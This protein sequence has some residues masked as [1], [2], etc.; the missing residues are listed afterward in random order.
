MLYR[1]LKIIVGIGIRFYYKEVKVLNRTSLSQDGPLIIIS[2]HP[3]TLMDAM[4]IGFACK[5]PIYYMAK[6][7]LFNSK[8]KLWLLQSLNMIPINRQG[9]GATKGVSNQDSF[10]AC[11]RIL[12]QNKTLV[13]FPEGT[14]FLERQLRELK[15]GTARIA[16]EV[17]KRNN[18]KLNL[19]VV[20]LG[21]N[22]L[23]GE[24]FR[25]SV[26]I[27]VG[28]KLSVIDFLEDYKVDAGKTAKKLT[29]KFR[30]NLETVLVNSTSKEQEFLVDDLVEILSSR[31]LRANDKGVE[32]DVSF[33]KDIRNKVEGLQL[34]DPKK[35]AE[36]QLLV[37]N[38]QW[39]LRKLDIRADFLDRRFRSLMFFRQMVF[40]VSFLI[41]GL[42]AF[43]FGIWHN[44]IQFKLTDYLVPKITKDIEYFAPIAVLLGLI[45]YPVFYI[46][47]FLLI[48]NL[49]QL[50]FYW[51]IIYFVSMPLSGMFAYSF[52]KYLDHIS[53][54][55]KYILMMFN[56]KKAI[57]ELKEKRNELRGMIF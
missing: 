3:N 50:P 43:I 53:Y 18:G 57:E 23:K 5:Q 6:G 1:L 8:L 47:F 35:I 54:K 29:E 11:Y 42:P 24:K 45:F 13:I 20:P 49:F 48:T 19:Q 55:W 40:S 34:T 56:D 26:L 36:I 22:Y 52:N 25:S 15:S 12:E 44:L 33:L 39:R 28:E 9:E 14:S 37:Q 31:Y 27:N 7:T 41:L 51:K 2:N 32:A 21:L 16:L 38:I 30:L 10:E 46:S 17:E 4:M